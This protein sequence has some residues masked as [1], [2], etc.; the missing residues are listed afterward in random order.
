MTTPRQVNKA[1]KK[2]GIEGEI[3]RDRQHEYYYFIGGLFDKVP[4][5]YCYN[6]K[7]WTTEEIINYI[8]KHL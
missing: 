3:V 2:E 4:S 1:I 6:L 7:G 8:K 5:I